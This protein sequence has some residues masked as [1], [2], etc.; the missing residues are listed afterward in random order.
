MVGA[1]PQAFRLGSGGRR[2]PGREG[3]RMPKKSRTHPSNHEREYG[4]LA[5]KHPERSGLFFRNFIA[6]QK[7]LQTFDIIGMFDSQELQ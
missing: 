6:N 2:R 7:A 4:S 1:G 3:R 5:E